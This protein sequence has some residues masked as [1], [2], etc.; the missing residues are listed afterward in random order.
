MLPGARF[1]VARPP[2]SACLHG[3]ALCLWCVCSYGP[4]SMA[5]TTH[6]LA[7]CREHG[8][9]EL[10]LFPARIRGCSPSP[11]WANATTEAAL[12]TFVRTADAAGVSVQL[13]VGPNKD[14]VDRVCACVEASLRFIQR[15]NL[16]AQMA[17]PPSSTSS[18]PA[19]QQPPEPAAAASSS[20]SLVR[21]DDAQQ[22]QPWWSTDSGRRRH[23]SFWYWPGAYGGTEINAS[24]ASLARHPGV[25]RSVLLSCGLGV[26]N[27]S[28]GITVD[29]RGSPR[30][31][32]AICQ[33]GQFGARQ[34]L[35]ARLKAMRV[36]PELVLSNGF[37]CSNHSNPQGG[38][39]V[40]EAD[41]ADYRAFMGNA[42]ANI[43]EMV[44]LGQEWGTGGWHFDLEPVRS[45][46]TRADA[47]LYAQFLSK[48]RKAFTAAGMRTSVSTARWTP[49]LGQYAALAGAAD[50]LMSMETYQAGSFEGWMK[51]DSYGGDYTALLQAAGPSHISPGFACSAG[52]GAPPPRTNH[53]NESGPASWNG[54]LCGAAACW[55]DSPASWAQRLQQMKR[56]GVREASV[57]MLNH[58]RGTWQCPNGE[59]FWRTLEDFVRP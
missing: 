59:E 13:F 28:A 39:C 52:S 40:E 6:F 44:R 23:V 17:A 53:D 32:S 33:H 9:D 34:G 20:S 30:N 16:Y 27:E 5:Y 25:V 10:Y 57:F 1:P 12:A 51:Q 35:I 29:P 11:T 37:V 47:A 31:S 46:S 26:S 38:S 45:G 56:D 21:S 55:S 18:R 48:A 24:L 15:E 22:T 7:W 19:K 41:V 2:E 58:R 4:G 36:V 54:T 42:T 8:V 49:F 3:C 43:A 50:V 14:W